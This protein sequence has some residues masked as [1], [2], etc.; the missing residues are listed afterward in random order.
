MP[1]LI[2]VKGLCKSFGGL[3]AVVDV[4]F[5]IQAGEIIGLI[6]PNGAGKTTL[7]N[8]ISGFTRPTSGR[9]EFAGRDITGWLPEEVCHL[10]LART[11]QVVRT[12][13]DMSVLDNV[14]IGAFARTVS[15]AE[16]ER[17]AREVLEL[18]GLASKAGLLGRNITIADKKRLELARALATHPR[19]LMLDEAMAGLNPAERQAAVELVRSIQAQGVTI[20]MVEHV[21]QVIMPIS[22]RVMVLNYGRKIAEGAPEIVAH[23]E[24]V[25]A[26][27]LGAK[28][29]QQA[30]S[31]PGP[32]A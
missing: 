31:L 19:L 18:T 28:Y 1:P 25:I 4:S 8:C 30:P 22:K 2:S 23:D 9:V 21:M 24:N 29:R 11:F 17:G 27:Y 12:F 6:G 10:G 20:L 14:L 3:T 7:F 16:A 15:R 26:A 32:A 5:E 13:P